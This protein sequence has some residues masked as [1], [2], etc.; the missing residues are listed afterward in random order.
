L[1]FKEGIRAIGKIIDRRGGIRDSEDRNNSP[2]SNIRNAKVEQKALTF[3]FRGTQV[4]NVNQPDIISESDPIPL[5][6]PSRKVAHFSLQ[7]VG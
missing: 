5:L 6:V 1:T 4:K 2:S 3:P 7:D